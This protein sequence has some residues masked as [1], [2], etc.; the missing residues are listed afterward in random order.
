MTE[1]AKSNLQPLTLEV[2]QY[3]T[4]ETSKEIDRFPKRPNYEA[5]WIGDR[6]WGAGILP[7]TAARHIVDK[8]CNED[9]ICLCRTF[10]KV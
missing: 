7:D 2:S 5:I 10:V 8:Y 9:C 4:T 3:N 1:T 6:S